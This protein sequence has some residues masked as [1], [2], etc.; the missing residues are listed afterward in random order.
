MIFLIFIIKGPLF[1]LVSI[2]IFLTCNIEGHD[3]TPISV[4]NNALFLFNV[5]GPL[6]HLDFTWVQFLLLSN[7]KRVFN[8]KGSSRHFVTPTILIFSTFNTTWIPTSGGSWIRL[9][10]QVW[11]NVLLWS[12]AASN[13]FLALGPLSTPWL[14][15]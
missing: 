10:I 4:K 11:I 7:I 12:T 8:F 14:V 6:R 3:G 15:Q 5:Q 1:D 13:C 2:L 9:K